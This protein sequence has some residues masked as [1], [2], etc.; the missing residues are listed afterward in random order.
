MRSVVPFGPDCIS[1][2]KYR[3]ALNSR[4]ELRR[5]LPSHAFERTDA[6]LFPTTPC[7]AP[8]IENQ[9]NFRV[10]GQDVTDVFLSRNTHP[11]SS[12]GVPGISLPMAVNAEGLPLGLELDA[13]AGRDRDL[14]ALARRV[15]RI[16]ARAEAT[17]NGAIRVWPCVSVSAKCPD[18]AW[19]SSSR[20]PVA[21]QPSSCA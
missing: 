11:S 2:E 9:W 3:A 15:E 16:L 13:A 1:E 20:G 12:A 14:L 4:H 18:P 8:R 19:P 7:A 10:A 21:S 5:R 6:L 17:Q